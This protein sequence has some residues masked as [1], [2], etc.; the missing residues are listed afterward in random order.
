[1]VYSCEHC[2][3]PI[4]NVGKIV[5]SGATYQC[6]PSWEQASHWH[7]RLSR[8]RSDPDVGNPRQWWVSVVVMYGQT[9]SPS[10]RRG[11]RQSE[12]GSCRAGQS[13]EQRR[14]SHHWKHK[15]IICIC[16]MSNSS[17]FSNHLRKMFYSLFYMTKHLLNSVS[18]SRIISVKSVV[19]EQF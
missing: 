2:F 4:N 5:V 14:P 13:H 16:L 18:P 9:R 15:H 8:Q 12:Q 10:D 1:M 6:Q 19:H 7:R 17:T 3:G 11:F